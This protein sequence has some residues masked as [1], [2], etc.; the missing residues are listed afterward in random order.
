MTFSTKE[1]ARY[2]DARD[3]LKRVHKGDLI[4]WTCNMLT[5]KRDLMHFDNG[6][7]PD[8]EHSYFISVRSNYLP[9]RNGDHFII[10][11]Y[12]PYIF[13]RQFR[14]YQE[15]PAFLKEDICDANLKEGLRHWCLINLPKSMSMVCFLAMTSNARSYFS[16]SYKQC[17]PKFVGL[18]LKIIS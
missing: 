13:S 14:Y 5:N 7:A 12:C 15:I 9:L 3:A 4:Y 2:Y 11:P 17:G 10:D 16:D 6:R 18:I 8:T 1:G